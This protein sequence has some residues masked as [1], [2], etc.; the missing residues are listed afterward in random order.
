MRRAVLVALLALALPMAAWANSDFVFNNNGGKVSVG[1][2][3]SLWLSGSSLTSFTGLNG[4]PITGTLGLVDF[5]TGS[6][7]SGSLGAG[8]I[9]AAGG[10]FTITGN[11]SNGLPNGVVFSG[12]FSGP[13]TWTASF[14]PSGFKGKGNWSYVLTGDIS[15]S[16]NGNPAAAGTVQLTFDVPRG[17]PFSTGANLNTGTT[18]VT[19][20]EPGTLGLLGTGL[21]GLAG[22]LR[23]KFRT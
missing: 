16:I 14:N 7:I 23:R 1:S 13:V 15:G 19:V 3:Q 6:L 17:K 20:P 18:T 9:F 2:G 4:V 10:S 22:L 11:G 21:V 12:S 5:S 8:G